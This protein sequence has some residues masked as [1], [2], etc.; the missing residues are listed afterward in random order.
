MVSSSSYY[1]DKLSAERLKKCYDIAPPRVK[2]YLEAEL[3]YVLSKIKKDDIVLELGCGYGR[4]LPQ[5]AG[6]ASQVYGI[7]NSE[8]SIELGKKFLTGYLNCT[9]MTMD[10][11]HL[12]FQDNTFDMVVCIQNG[13]SAFHVDQRELI[14]ESIRVTKQ[15]GIVIFS[16][17]SQKFWE[18][19]LEW[20][21]L[22]S[23]AGLLGEIDEE[24]TKDGNIVCKDGF[25][26][27]TVT[28]E[29]FKKLILGINDIE[30]VIEE[31]D[32]SSLFFEICKV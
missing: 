13:I 9:L 26:A 31:V 6:K 20:F 23:D 25:T 19:R 12:T 24:K 1:S 29:H 4:I 27:T 8:S 5:I 10:A 32:E 21:R 18:H 15:G 3:N 14:K 22:Q 2:Q 7:D 28:S 11:V 16:S 17:Y 30:L